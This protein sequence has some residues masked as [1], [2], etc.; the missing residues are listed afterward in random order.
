MPEGT[1]VIINQV[2]DVSSFCF[3]TVRT[4]QLSSSSNHILSDNIL[5]IFD[6]SGNLVAK[7]LV[8]LY[9]YVVVQNRLELLNKFCN[10]ILRNRLQIPLT[11]TLIAIIDT[12]IFTTHAIGASPEAHVQ[13]L[14]R[15]LTSAVAI[16]VK[17]SFNMTGIASQ[18]DIE[19]ILISSGVVIN[20]NFGITSIVKNNVAN[21]C[22]VIGKQETI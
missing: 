22:L 16:L 5:R 15:I 1:T 14:V 6:S 11:G 4:A 19:D 3:V 9:Q 21:L 17:V 7:F 2:T 8:L 18:T 20:I 10:L 13:I 12:T